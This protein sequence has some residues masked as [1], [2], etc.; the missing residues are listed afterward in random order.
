M[1]AV[2]NLFGT[3]DRFYGRQ[4]FHGRGGVGGDCSGGNVSD[5]EQWGAAVNID[6][7]LLASPP[8]TSCC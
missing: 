1:A 5:G 4:F 3:R 7:A 6:E 8:L 2:P